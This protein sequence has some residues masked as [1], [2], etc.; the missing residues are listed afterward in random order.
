MNPVP[1]IYVKDLRVIKD[2]ELKDLIL[3][4][5]SIVSFAFNMPNGVP[6]ASFTGQK[7]DEELLYLTT[8]LEEVYAADDVRHRIEKTFNLTQLQKQY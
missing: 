8:F 5:N 3:V 4:D 1:G 7:N 2:R 6:I